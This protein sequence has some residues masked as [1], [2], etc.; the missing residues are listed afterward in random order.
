MAG[1]YERLVG[2]EVRSRE[3]ELPAA[4]VAVRDLAAQLEGGARSS[5]A[6]ATSPAAAGRG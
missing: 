4:L 6:S 5:L 3:A 1:A 2:N